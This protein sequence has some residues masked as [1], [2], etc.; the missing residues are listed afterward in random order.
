MTRAED[1][2]RPLKFSWFGPAGKA[3]PGTG[4][5]LYDLLDPLLH[6]V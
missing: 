1:P 3:R 5:L 6:C 4:M 2:A